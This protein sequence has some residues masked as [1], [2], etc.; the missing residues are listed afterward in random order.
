MRSVEIHVTKRKKAKHIVDRR[1]IEREVREMLARRVSGT[2]LGT[3][4]LIPEHIRLGSWD[5]LT[6]WANDDSGGV[7]SRLALQ[8]VHEAAL[9][10]TG[11]REGRSLSH[12][13]FEIA[14]G[15]PFIAT[16][17]EIHKLLDGHTVQ[18]SKQLQINLARLRLSLGHYNGNLLAFDPH[19]IHTC[20]Q[21]IMPKKKSSPTARSKRIMQTFFSVDAETGQ[22]LAFTIGS[23]GK[24]TTRGSLELIEMIDT[25]LPP[26]NVLLVADTEHGSCELLDHIIESK[27]YDILMPAARNKVVMETIQKLPYQ[28]H[29][30]GYATAE[31]SYQYKD[32]KHPFRLIGQRS[33]E[34]KLE[35]E[36]KPFIATGNYPSLE[37]ITEKY[38]ARW[39]IEEFFN[40]EG[41]MGWDRTATMNLNI[42][43]GK[44]SLALIA[45]AATFQLKKKLPSPYKN[46]T[47]Q[48]LADSVFRGI[49][50]DLRVKDDTIIVTMYNVPE[51]LNLRQHY[52]NTPEK[53]LREGFDPRIPWLYDFKL[54]FRFK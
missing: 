43:Y 16:D 33:G 53:L 4:L 39:K 51:S 12:Q 6:T 21:R 1:T 15:L 11:I 44:L 35:Y 5:L 37:S 45:Q 42:R 19:R 32:S 22:P 52:E 46:W 25:I 48:H 20:S 31:I 8:M 28:R 41:A 24:T 14:N 9:C 50:G 18:E 40:F 26:G 34:N 29:W 10:L 27:H 23:S 49:D 2:L 3:W 38:P 47:A 13:S 36:Y 7:E 30:A 17:E 54:D